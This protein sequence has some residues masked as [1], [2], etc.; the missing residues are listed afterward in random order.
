R[1]AIL[2]GPSFRRNFSS[3]IRGIEDDKL[4]WIAA[5]QPGSDLAD[6][7]KHLQTCEAKG[8]EHFDDVV[9]KI[10]AGGLALSLTLLGL[11]KN[12][13]PSSMRWIFSAWFL[14]ALT[15]LLLMFSVLTGQLGLRSQIRHVDRG[16][17]RKAKRPEGRCGALT[18]WLNSAVIAT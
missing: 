9:F 5:P 7:R 18:P 1:S 17:Y 6:F 13:T 12:V 15:L 16:T 10:A 8:W 14:W 11:M 4:Y 3:T 2:H